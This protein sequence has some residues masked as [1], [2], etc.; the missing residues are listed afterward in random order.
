MYYSEK[1]KAWEFRYN[2]IKCI[3]RCGYGFCPVRSRM[4]VNEK[5]NVF[6]DVRVST[7]RKDGTFFDGQPIISV[8]KGRKFLER[9]VSM[10]ICRA[11]A[12][13][14]KEEIFRREWWNG[15]SMRK[16]YDPDLE[17]EILNIRAERR[18]CR[19]L[20]KD[21]EDLQNGISVVHESDRIKRQKEQKKMN[22]QKRL[23]RLGR[24]IAKGG[25]GSLTDAERRLA[26]KKIGP[27]RIKAMEQGR[28][29][30]Q[31]EQQLSLSMWMES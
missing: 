30:T 4:L 11:I 12:A 2:P 21:L 23:E 16:I 27:E 10:D 17:I 15:Y 25:Y 20:E 18:A 5:G 8:V 14:G 6:Y 3:G 22:K 29:G 7:V 31:Q 19:D 26:D 13:C 9:Q 28:P 1:D 24:K